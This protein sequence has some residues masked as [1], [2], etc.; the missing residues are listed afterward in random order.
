MNLL[1][2]KESP[3]KN[4]ICLLFLI[5]FVGI[6]GRTQGFSSLSEA[7]EIAKEIVEVS[8]KRANFGIKEANVPNAVAVLYQGKRYVLYNPGFIN[9]LTRATG[10]SWAAV[11]VLAHEIGHHLNAKN[12]TSLATELEAD[13]F[14]GFILQKMGASLAEAQVAMKVIANE[15]ASRTHPAKSQRLLSIADGWTSAGGVDTVTS[16]AAVAKST[17]TET[18]SL[19][20]IA[21]VSFHADPNNKYYLTRN[22]NIVRVINEDILLVGKLTKTSDRNFPFMIYNNEGT[23]VYINLEGNIVSRSGKTVGRITDHLSS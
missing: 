17:V 18:T 11:S 6:T 4:K 1:R 5:L 13:E 21:D 2:K 20:V 23:R 16:T 19:P 8:G 14:S 9:T 15:R 3:L 10:S 22:L 12:A 7:A